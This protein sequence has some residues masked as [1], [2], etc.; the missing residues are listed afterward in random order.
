TD[1]PFTSLP[2]ADPVLPVVPVEP[3]APIEP[4]PVAPPPASVERTH[5]VAKGDTLGEISKQYY[6]TTKHWKKIRD[7]NQCDENGLAVGQKL[8]IPAIDEAPPTSVA[9]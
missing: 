7:I 1:T 2:P 6:G 5:T 3:I 4:I 9:T 8:T